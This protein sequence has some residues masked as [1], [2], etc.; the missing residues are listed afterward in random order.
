M[1]YS[2][3]CATI[4]TETSC[5]YPSTFEVRLCDFV[6]LICCLAA[7]ITSGGGFSLISSMPGWQKDYV[8]NY[9]KIAMNLPTGQFNASNRAFPD[10]S[11]NGHNYGVI[12]TQDFYTFDGYVD[13]ILPADLEQILISMQ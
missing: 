12:L 1:P 8:N 7:L 5:S 11:A 10:V 13:F 9:L 3:T 2:F 4:T 6:N